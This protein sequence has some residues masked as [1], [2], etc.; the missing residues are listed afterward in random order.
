MVARTRPEPRSLVVRFSRDGEPVETQ[1]AV[2]GQQARL[3]AIGMMVAR[4]ILLVGD[5]LHVIAG[6]DDDDE[7]GD[8]IA[9]P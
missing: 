6:P 3:L 9:H 4:R 5:A 7:S 8:V 1:R 2:D